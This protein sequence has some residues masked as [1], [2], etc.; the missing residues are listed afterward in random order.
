MNGFAT[1]NT[2]STL[3]FRLTSVKGAL[4]QALAHLGKRDSR[5]IGHNTYLVKTDEGAI[6]RFHATNILTFTRKGV[7]LNSG[8]YRTYTT[9]ERINDLLPRGFSIY[10]NKGI[11]YLRSGEEDTATFAD[12]LTIGG[13]GKVTSKGREDADLKLRAT[14]HTYAHAFA[15]A[16]MTGKVEKPG[17]GDCWHCG[18]IV[19]E[20]PDKG[21]SLGD[22]SG[23]KSHLILHMSA[24][25]RYYVPSLL[26]NAAKAQG[27]N[28]LEHS[29]WILWG[30]MTDA[31]RAERLAREHRLESEI[32]RCVR[33]Y[34]GSRLGLA[35]R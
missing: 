23:D 28:Y 19:T 6:V 27:N 4:A 15:R 34:I 3:D 8:G 24:A 21:K 16:A 20:G 7:T 11:W 14:I 18:M 22:A 12:G 26:V 25:E 17:A 31:E 30:D 29:F 2:L 33:K 35:L 10:S 32:R 9:K 1:S 5:K 13:T